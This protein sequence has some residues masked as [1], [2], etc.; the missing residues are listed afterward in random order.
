MREKRSDAAPLDQVAGIAS[1]AVQAQRAVNQAVQMQ[2]SAKGAG[3]VQNAAH[4]SQAA[5]A[6]TAAAKGG[7]ASAGATAGTAFGGPLGPVVGA[8]ATNKN[9]WKVVGGIFAALFLWMFL[10][11]NMIGI[12]LT[13]LGFADADA[14]ANE[15]QSA[16]LSNIK[17]RIESILKKE[18]YRQEILLL[19]EQAR[20]QELQEIQADK[21]AEYPDYEITVV[22]EYES[23]LKMNTSYYLAILLSEVWDTSDINSFLGYPSDWGDMSTDLTSKYDAYFEEAAEAYGVPVAL[24]KAMGMAESGFN[25]NAVSGA[26]AIGV[27]QLMPGTAASL[28]VNPHN[29]REN[30][31]GGAKYIAKNLEQ[32]KNHSNGLELAIAAY[33]AGPGNV[34][35]YGYQIPPFK[36]TQNYVKKVLGY[37]TIQERRAGSAEDPDEDLSGPYSQL[38]EAVSENT[39][40]IFSWS[41]TGEGEN[42]TTKTVYYQLKESGKTEIGKAAYEKLKAEGKQVAEERIPAKVKSVEYTLALILSSQP[43]SGSGYEYKYVT[44]QSTFE[45]VL[46]VLKLMSEGIDSLKDSFFSLFSWRDFVTGG[47]S[48][49]YIGN[50]DA[51]G[52]IIT[53]DTVGRGVKRVVYF[54]QGEEP[55]KRMP[56]GTSTIGAAGCGPTSLAIVISTLTGQT[57]T[58]QT[59]CA[60]SIQNG[61]Y[62]SGVGTAHSFPT[63][64]AKHWGLTCE[65]VGK[66]RMDYVVQSLKE[67]KMVVEICEAYTITGG[68][69]GHFIVLTGVTRDGY[70]TIA[71]CASRERTGKV[72]SVDTIK[73][74]GRDLSAGA[75]WIIGK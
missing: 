12:I 64:A 16:E 28:G 35:K 59:T 51:T 47:G 39:D 42:D 4:T 44:S 48:D 40:R 41:V 45:L 13:Y 27:M 43:A 61:E 11:A 56:Y 49:S 71:D 19:I 31:M 57:V 37:I 7:G 54:N 68:S 14:F 73:S 75:F 32:F 50:I 72:Y 3:A 18:E 74:Y 21:E 24:L 70:I 36:E 53:Y 62:V 60:F 23:K 58:P 5:Y 8:F 52:D 67:G 25:Q 10:I 2:K 9:F 1:Q 46:K 17:V 38:K 33:N 66:D 22:D 26:G 63:N 65:R 29:A 20:D 15:A 69:S 55:W 34:I 30:I 6:V